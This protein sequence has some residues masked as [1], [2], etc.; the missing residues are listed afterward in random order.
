MDLFLFDERI[1][2]VL[3]SF[4]VARDKAGEL[5]ESKTGVTPE[6][7]GVWP[8]LSIKNFDLCV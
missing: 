3:A 8:P 1:N 2:V 7:I 6:V 5:T 4:L